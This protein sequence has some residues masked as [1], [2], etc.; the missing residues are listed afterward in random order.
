MNKF[1]ITMFIF[2]V[3]LSLSS[4]AVAYV[5]ESTNYKIESDSIN[6]GGTEESAS[7]SYNL[8]DTF[9]ELATG[10]SSSASFELRAGYRAMEVADSAAVFLTISAPG[11]VALGEVNVGEEVTGQAVWN[12]STNNSGGYRLS[13]KSST[14]PALKSGDDSFSDYTPS[15]SDPDYSWSV[16]ENETG[17]G[18][19][20]QGTHIISRFKDNSSS[21]AT[22]SSDTSASCWVGFATTNQT[23]AE[24]SSA[25]N[26]SG[27]NTTV[28]MKA[29][30]GDAAEIN[31]GDYTA[32]II[33]TAVTL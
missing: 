16:G 32:N 11:D 15:G 9:G 10:D 7:A 22:G 8:S 24:G 25:N 20:P 2:S 31:S 33:A 5:A 23:I 18:F 13:L 12:V 27:T 28:I 26:P 30:I 19:S 4:M 14:D 3:F 21:C 1:L 29:A 6:F 17:F